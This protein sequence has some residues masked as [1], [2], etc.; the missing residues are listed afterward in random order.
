M[1]QLH[2]QVFC[3]CVSNGEQFQVGT[4]VLKPTPR[5]SDPHL[6][7][8]LHLGL[9]TFFTIKLISTLLGAG[10]IHGRH[11]LTQ[12]AA[13]YMRLSFPALARKHVRVGS[14]SPSMMT[15]MTRHIPT[16]GCAWPTHWCTYLVSKSP[17]LKAVYH[18]CPQ[19]D[20][21]VALYYCRSFVLAVCTCALRIT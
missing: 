7:R 5:Q 1:L 18:A 14:S 2:W 3:R 10:N 4:C 11:R 8:R 19:S 20:P 13:I 15:S 6:I 9:H 12:A 21:C 16:A 17:S